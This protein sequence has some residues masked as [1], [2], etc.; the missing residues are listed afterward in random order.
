M[1][2]WRGRIKQALINQVDGKD[3]HFANGRLVRNLYDDI[4]MNHAKRVVDIDE[5]SRE[6]LSLITDENFIDVLNKSTLD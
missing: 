1:K 3:E 2:K 4:V 6:I 5:P